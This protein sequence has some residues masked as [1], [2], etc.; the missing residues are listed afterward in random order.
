MQLIIVSIDQIG[1]SEISCFLAPKQVSGRCDHAWGVAHLDDAIA[2]ISPRAES[3]MSDALYS[4]K[5]RL[6]VNLEYRTGLFFIAGFIHTF[7]HKN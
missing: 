3:K 4:G 7:S 6:R 2:E 1:I 5:A